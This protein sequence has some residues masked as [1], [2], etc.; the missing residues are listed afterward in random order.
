MQADGLEASQPRFTSFEATH[1]AD[2]D[3]VAL[4]IA[5]TW[6][7]L[8]SGFV[9]EIMQGFAQGKSYHPITHL[10]AASAVGWMLLLTWQAL[11]VRSGNMR[12]HKAYG[13]RIGPWL[14]I[15]VT[16][17]ALVTVW[18]TDRARIAVNDFDP[19]R[20][21]F[22]IGHIIPFAVL[23]GIA[24]WRTDRPALHKRLQLLAVIAV[25]DTGWSRWLGSSMVELFGRGPAGMML[26]RFPLTW[27]LIAA[28][29]IYDIKTRGRL[30]GAFL[31]SVALII[32]TEF[33]ACYLYFEPWWS[34]T[35]LWMLGL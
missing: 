20:L 26:A 25:L 17:S 9:P 3:A 16:V 29:A 18:L 4:M 14:A 19:R 21:S 6:F 27:A 28:M 12:R 5:L 15:I 11:A 2:R 33:G 22:Q 7:G 10:H 31:P 8:L 35:A 34:Q 13:R 24:L 32:A 1:P 30:H 23:S